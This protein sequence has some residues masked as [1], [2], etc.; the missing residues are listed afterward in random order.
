MSGG[1]D[2]KAQPIFSTNR[3]TLHSAIKANVVQGSN[4]YTD[5]ALAYR[6][7]TGYQ[8][9]AVSHSVGEYV[10]G[11]PHTNGIESFWALLKRGYH[12]VY[13]KMER[14]HLHRYIDEFATRHNCRGHGT[15]TMLNQCIR[16]MVGKSLT[17]KELTQ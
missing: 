6:S 8:H 1:G 7:I 2:V 17:Y 15:E 13:H 12:G 5:E 10:N 3:T 11:M 16:L 4:V 9:Q 14:K